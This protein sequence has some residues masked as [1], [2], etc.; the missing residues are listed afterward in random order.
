MSLSDESPRQARIVVEWP[1]LC[2]CDN[3]IVVVVVFSDAI[4]T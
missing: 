1:N 3:F 4:A 2:Y